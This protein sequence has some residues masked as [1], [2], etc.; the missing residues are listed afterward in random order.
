[1]DSRLVVEHH[2][3]TSEDVC[4]VTQVTLGNPLQQSLNVQFVSEATEIIE[5]LSISAQPGNVYAVLSDALEGYY[6]VRCKTVSRNSFSGVYLTQI[7]TEDPHK[8]LYQ[9]SKEKDTFQMESIVAELTHEMS[10]VG[11][12][13]RF[14]VIKDELISVILTINEI[15]EKV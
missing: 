10:S 9:E 4:S 7:V 13:K 12:L 8:L 15:G 14:L 3:E 5:S 1:M 11:K 2:L 6:I